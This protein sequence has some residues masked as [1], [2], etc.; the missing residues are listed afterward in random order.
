MRLW[1]FVVKNIIMKSLYKK[2]F[3]ISSF[4][5]LIISI[6]VIGYKNIGESIVVLFRDVC[7]G[8]NRIVMSMLIDSY[9]KE[10]VNLARKVLSKYQVSKLD[11]VCWTHPHYDHSPGI[12][13]LINEMF[14]ENIVIF[15]PKFYYGN[16]IPDLLKAES[17]KTPEIFDNIWNRVKTESNFSE[18][19]RT[20][21]ANG[22]ATHPYQLQIIS[23]DG[24]N[25]KDVCF[26][27][28]TPLSS[29]TDKYAIKGNEFSRP[30]ELSVSF[31]LSVDGYDFYFGGDAENEHAIGICDEIVN[32]MRWI[33]VPHHCS[34]G[35]K[36]IAERLGARFDYA[37]STVYKSS[38]LPKKDVQ[39]L[40]AKAGN[41]HMTQLEEN[42][43][44]KLQHEY[45]IIQ[46]DY[47][48]TTLETRVD[49]T[50]Y[51]N[52]GQYFVN[53]SAT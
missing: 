12:D 40:Y 51:G 29:R 30:N 23:E 36:T 24:V 28:L 16:L 10:N 5:N 22:D 1:L 53:E 39:N 42:D 31:I 7:N 9:E 43:N 33:K 18:I 52:A 4:E 27:F 3:K 44:F 48:F 25:H 50:T 37:A 38:D 15:S 14:H 32:S 49:I 11:F 6:F 8:D 35:A 19:W 26:Y 46:Y 34:L 13:S 41:L 20:V 47:H 2:I 21:S 17:I 45:G